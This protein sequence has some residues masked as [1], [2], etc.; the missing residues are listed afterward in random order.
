MGR[1][2]GSAAAKALVCKK[3]AVG[4]K[5]A[6]KIKADKEK[7]TIAEII[8]LL[9]RK[10]Q[11]IPLVLD[12]LE[13]DSLSIVDDQAEFWDESFWRVSQTPSSWLAAWLIGT[14]SLFTVGSLEQLDA[15]N[16]HHVRRLC[17]ATGIDFGQW[18]MPTAALGKAVCKK[19]MDKRHI[20][21]GSRLNNDWVKTAVSETDIDW[22]H[23]VFAGV[24]R[25]GSTQTEF[26]THESGQRVPLPAEL[27]MTSDWCIKE[28]WSD[29]KACIQKGIIQ[30]VA[31]KESGLFK[32]HEQIRKYCSY[33]KWEEERIVATAS[34]VAAKKLQEP[35][36][37]VALDCTKD[38]KIGKQARLN[39]RAVPAKASGVS[40]TLL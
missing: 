10:P 7:R 20:A 22:T 4:R 21:L 37:A 8:E 24:S 32:D 36:G 30:L 28:N 11:A 16:G 34:E 23:G 9:R 15:G 6:T 17:Q 14:C 3:S 18:R 1:K 26:I 39:K 31:S 5:S 27:P 2:R 19:V 13:Q 25:A 38:S 29:A 12:I 40:L 35:E 33:D